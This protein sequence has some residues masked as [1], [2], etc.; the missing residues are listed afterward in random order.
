MVTIEKDKR[1]K[2]KKYEIIIEIYVK[3]VTN[4]IYMA[5]FH[6]LKVF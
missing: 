6:S 3:F 4:I 2:D 1:L 5:I